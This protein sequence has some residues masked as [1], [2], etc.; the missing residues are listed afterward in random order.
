MIDFVLYASIS[1]MTESN[2]TSPEFAVGI[3]CD[4]IKRTCTA[5]YW[6]LNNS[7]TLSLGDAR[8]DMGVICS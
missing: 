7:I 5:K 6:Q 1:C 4:E 8:D 2:H 3:E